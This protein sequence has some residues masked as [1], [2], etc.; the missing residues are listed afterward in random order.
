M[1]RVGRF[2]DLYEMMQTYVDEIEQ[3]EIIKTISEN[4]NF[5]NEY[6]TPKEA[7][8][9]VLQW[10]EQLDNTVDLEEELRKIKLLYT[11]Q[12]NGTVTIAG[13]RVVFKNN[14]YG[15]PKPHLGAVEIKGRNLQNLVAVLIT[16]QKPEVYPWEERIVRRYTLQIGIQAVEIHQVINSHI[17]WFNTGYSK[18][19]L[20]K[21]FKRTPTYTGRDKVEEAAFPD[22]ALQKAEQA[23]ILL[24]ELT[25][26]ASTSDAAALV[27]AQRSD[28]NIGRIRE[29]EL[30]VMA[31]QDEIFEQ[32][33]LTT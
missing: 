13:E 15:K 24:E 12:D 33:D 8:K 21:P 31:L 30:E 29:L 7:L 32:K 28:L 27:V 25:E 2:N 19:K 17:M 22:I 16:N 11:V 9:A 5:E 23:E 14:K 4:P 6:S 20:K 18:D 26:L 3:E 1:A 10:Q